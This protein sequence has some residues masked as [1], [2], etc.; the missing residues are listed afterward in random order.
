[1]K[2]T[3]KPLVLITFFGLLSGSLR[4]Q[5]KLPVTSAIVTD[6][7]K[8]LADYPNQFGSLLGEIIRENPQSTEYQCNFNVNG[9][10]ESIITRYSSNKQICS[11]EALMLTTENFDKAR[12]KYRSLFNQLNHLSADV[13]EAR[14]IRFNGRYEAPEEEK[15]F[16]SVLFETDSGSG[17]P[18][19]MELT[20]E[21]H[22]PAE[23]KVKLLLYDRE[24]EDHERG[25][26]RE[27][28]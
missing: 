5:L 21:F 16:S 19:K 23:W 11:W 6:V 17:N 18:L 20:M 12:Q 8:V 15:K 10:E 25:A 14:L 28:N 3:V 7:K 24:R 22:V 4:A 1:M 9:A 26:I 13:G 2:K 27:G